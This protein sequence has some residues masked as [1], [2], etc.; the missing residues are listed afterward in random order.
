MAGTISHLAIADKIYSILGGEVI[1]NLPLFFGGNLAPDAIH[2]KPNFQ[3]AD[4]KHTHLCDGIGS[5][6]YGYPEVAELFKDRVNEFIEK[7]YLTANED[8]DLYLGYVVHLLVDEFYLLKIYRHIEERLKDKGVDTDAPDFRK[9]LADDVNNNRYT[10]FA[11]M[12]KV[13]DVS[14]GNYKF[15]QNVAE[16]LESVWDYEVK[17]YVGA[18]EINASKRWVIDT[19]LKSEPTQD[20]NSDKALEFIELAAEDVIARLSGKYG[21]IKSCIGQ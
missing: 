11:Y 3:R 5:Y 18:Y 20:N 21:G 6:G 14:Q 8:K 9:N 15:T 2:A 13:Y 12:G 1:K 16:V 17:D 4:K 10:D 19:C 7:Y